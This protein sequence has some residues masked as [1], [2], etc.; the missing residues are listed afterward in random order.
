MHDCQEAEAADV[1]YGYVG[2]L[3]SLKKKKKKSQS[4]RMLQR[5]RN[6]GRTFCEM[7]QANHKKTHTEESNVVTLLESGMAVARGSGDGKGE[8]S[9]FN[10]YRISILQDE[11]VLEIHCTIKCM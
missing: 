8:S 7:K 6:L 3:F 11:E 4:R 9:S 10:G 2:I 1:V 5:G